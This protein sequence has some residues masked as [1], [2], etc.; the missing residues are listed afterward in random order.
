MGYL[1]LITLLICVLLLGSLF[2]LLARLRTP[3]YQVTKQHVMSILQR[4]ID[5]QL[6][7]SE[8]H[9]FIGLPIQ[10]DPELEQVRQACQ[11]LDDTQQV[12]PNCEQKLQCNEQA[13][14]E[15]NHL[16]DQLKRQGELQC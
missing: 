7:I 9:I 11:H 5:Q 1:F 10:H 13:V 6:D 12:K 14:K 16:I 3:H 8:W 2:Y 4:A 15:I